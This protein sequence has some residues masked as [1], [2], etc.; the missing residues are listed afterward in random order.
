M[1]QHPVI[2]QGR[3]IDLTAHAHADRRCRLAEGSATGNPRTVDRYDDDAHLGGGKLAEVL[4]DDGGAA[5]RPLGQ[6][7]AGLSQLPRNQ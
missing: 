7:G 2:Q 4:R 5:L 3:G 1:H 6:Q